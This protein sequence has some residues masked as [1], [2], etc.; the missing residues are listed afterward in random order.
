VYDA[1]EGKGGIGAIARD[2]NE[3]FITMVCKE[4]HFGT[5][6]MMAETYALREGLSLT[7]YL[8][9]NKFIIQSDCS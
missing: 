1:D 7:R 6:G 3:T 8:G 2:E 4:L 9:C 5:N